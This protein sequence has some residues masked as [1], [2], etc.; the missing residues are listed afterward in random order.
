MKTNIKNSLFGILFS[1]FYSIA[2]AAILSI[3]VGSSKDSTTVMVGCFLSLFIVNAYHIKTYL[4]MQ[5]QCD[6]LYKEIEE[7]KNRGKGEVVDESYPEDF[8]EN[9]LKDKFKTFNPALFKA[10]IRKFDVEDIVR[11]Y[12]IMQEEFN[13]ILKERGLL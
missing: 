1:F 12:G 10:Y 9:Y 11:A 3:A 2:P 8:Q 5:Y 13:I 7:L 4:M 6:N